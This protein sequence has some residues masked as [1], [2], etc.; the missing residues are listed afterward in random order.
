MQVFTSNDR[1]FGLTLQ[2]RIEL[3]L[4]NN[5]MLRVWYIDE[6]VKENQHVIGNEAKIL[7]KIRKRKEEDND[8][9]SSLAQIAPDRLDLLL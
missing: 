4:S 9:T 1:S 7:I 8:Q 5:R 2:T 3:K 6:N